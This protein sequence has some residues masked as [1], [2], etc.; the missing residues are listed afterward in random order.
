PEEEDSALRP[1][2]EDSEVS[3]PEEEASEAL[4]P[5]E[6]DSDLRPE[7]EDSVL[8]P[9]GEDSVLRAE[10]GLDASKALDSACDAAQ[11]SIK[12]VEETHKQKKSKTPLERS[13]ETYRLLRRKNLIVEMVHGVKI[14]EG[15]YPLQKMI[16]DEEK[17]SGVST[18]C[19]KKSV[20]R[21]ISVLS[22]EGLLK[23]YRTTV[24]QDGISRKTAIE[25]VRFRISGSYTLARIQHEQS[26]QAKESGDGSSTP[27]SKSKKNKG[28]KKSTSPEA[29]DSFRPTTIPG[30]SRTLGFQ[31]KMHR[32]RLV[33]SFLWYMVHGPVQQAS[34]SVQASSEASRRAEDDMPTTSSSSSSGTV[35]T[36][37]APAAPE[38]R[39]SGE[40]LTL[41]SCEK[42]PAD[43]ATAVPATPQ[44][45]GETSL[46][47]DEESI[48]VTEESLLE[49]SAKVYADELS[50]KRFLPP[51]RTHKEFGNGWTL[52]S[53][54]VLCLPLSIFVQVIQ[55]NYKSMQK[56]VYMGLLQFGPV[57]KFQDKDQVFVYVRQRGT[58]VDTTNT[59]PHYWQV[60]ECPDKPFD[61]RRYHFTTAEDVE[62]YWG[63]RGGGA[64]GGENEIEN[65]AMMIPEVSRIR[66]RNLVD[67]LKGSREVVDDGLIPGDGKGAGG[68]DSEFFGHL[69]RNWLWTNYLLACKKN[70]TDGELING[71]MRLKGLL[72]KNALRL[73][74]KAASRNQQVIGGK[75]QKRKRTRKE[76]VKVPRKKRKEPRKRVPA[77]DE[78]D[79]RALKMMTRKRVYWSPPEDSLIMLCSVALRRPFVPYC[80][81]R[82][83]LHGELE[84]SMDK[85]SVAVGR[86]TSYILKNPQTMLNHR[87]CL[88]EVY[89]DKA[90]LEELERKKPSDPNKPEFSSSATAC[91]VTVPDTRSQL[92]S[93]Y[94]VYTI[95]NQ[96]TQ[97]LRDT[98]SC[99]EDIHA[100]VLHN[101]VQSTLVMSNSQMKCSRSFQTFHMYSLFN[102]EVLC[103]VFIQVR[104]RG[105]VN[106]RRVHKTYGPKKNRAL[107]ILP[108][109]YQLSQ[110]YYRC[111][112]W[113]FPIALCTDA[114]SFIRALRDNGTSD[115]HK[116]TDFYKEGESRVD[117]QPP[118]PPPGTMTTPGAMTTHEEES[119]VVQNERKDKDGG[120]GDGG[121]GGVTEEEVVMEEKAP[122]MEEEEVVVAAAVL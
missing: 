4:R 69:K 6:E 27:A 67:L 33:H 88:A 77:H 51:I 80:V 81:V 100:I 117:A 57:E 68:L 78:A 112:T 54:V 96:E 49:A 24:I 55:V 64:G 44:A 122:V 53:D 13:H 25:Q 10:E 9:K 120:D 93:R 74:L 72:S 36:P 1:G 17:Q 94:K 28:D 23:M 95:D 66:F 32:L 82:D 115:T 48:C 14:V 34:G 40:S 31:P 73:A 107:P 83:M 35:P 11:E 104:K 90:L 26:K 113:R 89:Q 103:Q 15:L 85:T 108:M 46:S 18:K 61:R 92:F 43:A 56:L 60:I 65:P 20:L 99:T 39:T 102:Q 19:C 2:E 91:D 22:K 79:H 110:T 29:Q 71:N 3:R 116:T 8:R 37:A 109:S 101:L 97:P 42:T 50:W 118:P 47:G 121:G 119:P 59:E 105:L 86:R 45:S 41:S 87:I 70:I 52:V 30:L 75:R 76:V 84:K 63:K 62:N 114:F 111:F 38:D 16:N 12:V 7:G 98:L 21:L 106:R 5:K 58:I